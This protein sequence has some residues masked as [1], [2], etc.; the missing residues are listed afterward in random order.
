MILE[1][2]G[3]PNWVCEAR[4]HAWASVAFPDSLILTEHFSISICERCGAETDDQM[5]LI[6]DA[7]ITS[8]TG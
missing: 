7:T 6:Y 4:G 3:E 5:E 8:V 2:L 1:P